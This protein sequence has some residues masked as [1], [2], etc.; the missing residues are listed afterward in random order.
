MPN[1]KKKKK[2]LALNDGMLKYMPNNINIFPNDVVTKHRI[3]ANN[4]VILLFNLIFYYS[5]CTC[6]LATTFLLILAVKSFF[7]VCL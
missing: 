5:Y 3:T 1:P 2:R 6:L 4:K 7:L